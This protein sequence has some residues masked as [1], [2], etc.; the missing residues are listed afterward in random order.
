M[1]ETSSPSRNSS[2]TTP[3]AGRRRRG[4]RRMTS[5]IASS[6]CLDRGAD[7]DALPAREP[8]GPS[9]RGGRR[10]PPSPSGRR[11]RDPR[12]RRRRPSAT[13][14]AG[15]AAPFVNA[16]EPSRRRGGGR[17]GRT[18]GRAGG[19]CKRSTSPSVS[20]RLGAD[21][22]EGRCAPPSRSGGAPRRPSTA[23]GTQ[24]ATSADTGVPRRRTRARSKPRA[25]AEL[26]G[27]WRARAP[28]A[29]DDETA[30]QCRKC[31]HAG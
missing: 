19:R 21:D 6:A 31:R 20:G 13:R 10:R 27:E 14:L 24:S 3:R 2:M 11:R 30:H 23:I 15:G 18:R 9:R 26:P 12:R 29:T 1:K 4:G 28:P 25:L 17:W 16:F 22:R 5:S 8:V 7:E